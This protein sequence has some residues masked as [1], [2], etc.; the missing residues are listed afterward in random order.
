MQGLLHPPGDD[1]PKKLFI[2]ERWPSTVSRVEQR[3]LPLHRLAE[4]V[5][6]R[7]VEGRIPAKGLLPN[8]L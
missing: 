4:C 6:L 1:C 3:E 2:E 8:L 7:R 5:K